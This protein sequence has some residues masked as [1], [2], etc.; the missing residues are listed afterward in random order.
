M[1]WYEPQPAGL[2]SWA[3]ISWRRTADDESEPRFHLWV[4]CGVPLAE[5]GRRAEAMERRRPAQQIKPA[6]EA[7]A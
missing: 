5:D 1:T 7:A 4:R 3:I 6:Q 2:E